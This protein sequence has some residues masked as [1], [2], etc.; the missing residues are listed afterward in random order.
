MP[1]CVLTTIKKALQKS[2]KSE[3][4]DIMKIGIVTVYNSYNVGS[5][6]QAYSLQK[7][8]KE[9]GND[10]CFTKTK[11][12]I[13]SRFYYRL[14]QAIKYILVGNPKRA[15]Y[16][17]K[18]YFNFKKAH[19]KFNIVRN[20]KNID[21]MIYG[22]DTIWNF[23][24]VYFLNLKN[25]FLGNDFSGKKIAY[26]VSM[27]NTTDDKMVSAIGNTNS[28]NKFSALALRDNRTYNY[29]K[30][31]VN[32]EICVE[33]VLDPTFLI[34]PEKYKEILP[35]CPDENYIFFYYF[36]KVPE[37]VVKIVKEYAKKTNRKII[38]LGEYVSWADKNII[39]EPFEILSYLYN[40]DYI[41]TNTFHGSVFSLIFNKQFIDFGNNKIKI[42]ELLEEFSLTER[43]A[44]ENSDFSFMF[45]K[46]IDYDVVNK[47]IEVLREHSLNYLNN[48]L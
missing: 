30:E 6:W 41:I 14:L 10:V 12:F 32:E 34:E 31:N 13:K 4:C 29:V 3:V 9:K 36:C 44:D 22:S 38:V 19:R 17:L 35:K 26:A 33:K 48:V 39:V 37:N 25:Y 1:I 40:A 7:V 46:I 45:D 24:D 47:K 5:F 11:P 18:V 23:E 20:S 15:Y 21:L 16:L 8:L 28:L 43:F 42:K 27:A 2:K